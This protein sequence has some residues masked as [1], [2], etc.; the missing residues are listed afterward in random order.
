VSTESK[1][2]S[3]ALRKFGDKDERGS[4]LECGTQFRFPDRGTISVLE[5]CRQQS[6]LLQ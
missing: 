5:I 2:I 3:K 6:T 1:R 4:V